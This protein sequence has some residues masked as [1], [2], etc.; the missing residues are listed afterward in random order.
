M[1][2]PL[3]VI[4][5]TTQR[6]VTINRTLSPETLAHSC[7]AQRS[8][9]LYTTLPKEIRDL[10]FAF[11]TA[12]TPD[13]DRAYA[14]TDYWY[15]P[16]HTAALRTSTALLRTCRRVWLE[17][18]ALP[19]RQAVH[20]FWFQRGPYDTR[21]DR[22]WQWNLQAEFGR[23]RDW[24]A[25]LT[26]RGLREVRLVHVFMQMHALELCVEE[27]WMTTR[28]FPSA[29]VEKGFRPKVWRV[30]IRHS[31]WADWERGQELRL[32]DG[33]VQNLLDAEELGVVEELRLELET[34]ESRKDQLDEI[35]QRLVLLE[36]NPKLV[37]PT[38]RECQTAAKFV[39]NTTPTMDTW[40]GPT[41]IN[42]EDRAIFRGLDRLVYISKTITWTN[43]QSAILEQGDAK[44]ATSRS[45]DPHPARFPATR[46]RAYPSRELQ[47]AALDARARR[48]RR[49]NRYGE[50]EG[51]G[52]EMEE[53][54]KSLRVRVLV[55]QSRRL[56]LL[57]GVAIV[58]ASRWQ[59]S[60][61]SHLHTF[62]L[63]RVC[64][65]TEAVQ[66]SEMPGGKQGSDFFGMCKDKSQDTIVPDMAASVL[67]TVNGCSFQTSS[68]EQ[69]CFFAHAPTSSCC[70]SRRGDTVLEAQTPSS[71]RGEV[72]CD[73]PDLSIPVRAVGMLSSAKSARLA[74]Q[75]PVSPVPD[76]DG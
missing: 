58:A 71:S 60:E 10:I 13:P 47:Q 35:V 14:A 59:Y 24:A 9:P 65:A 52:T 41:D 43:V 56:S 16:G 34:L 12:P 67:F 74:C 25:K 32:D 28:F 3:A 21:P 66:T 70:A 54:E 2:S 15:R 26:A 18:H 38:N 1:E 51:L 48:I 39:C 36:G 27:R 19:L 31:D 20:A 69:R 23:Y 61:R 50:S 5:R 73:E 64:C 57:F 17:A 29:L 45:L 37:E 76:R 4:E 8:S 72:F 63:R 53:G 46:W 7:D 68:D 40:T 49:R 6:N 44:I 42:Q 22:L 55:M 75:V 30:T 11:A 33:L 62:K